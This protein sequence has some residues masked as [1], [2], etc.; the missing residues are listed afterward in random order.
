MKKITSR[1][2]L[3]MLLLMA[4]SISADGHLQRRRHLKKKHLDGVEVV[5]DRPGFKGV[6][7]TNGTMPW[8]SPESEFADQ[9]DFVNSARCAF[10]GQS[11][12]D[13]R[14]FEKAFGQWKAVIKEGKKEGWINGRR[15]NTIVIPTYFHVM[16]DG[17]KG[18]ISEKM[19][20]D[21]MRVLN[22][23]FE[24]AGFR[25][26]LMQQDGMS[27]SRTNNKRWHQGNACSGIL[28]RLHPS[29]QCSLRL[30]FISI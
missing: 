1:I 6:W 29:H 22:E 17:S 9:K 12:K 13:E 10:Q 30:L 19:I 24:E 26:V 21:Q 27:A 14:L 16:T 23:A 5:G 3:T 20:S 8:I 15:L 2:Q 18:D 4:L 11:K 25:F 7:T 28:C